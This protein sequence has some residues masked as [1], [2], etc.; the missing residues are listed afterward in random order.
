[1]PVGNTPPDRIKEAGSNRYP[2][3]ALYNSY[4]STDARVARVRRGHRRGDRGA[5]RG[6]GVRMVSLGVPL[7]LQGRGALPR[8][9]PQEEEEEGGQG[10][11]GGEAIC[12][13][14]LGWGWGVG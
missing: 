12:D 10:P 14:I 9:P 3:N 6:A 1:M 13:P 7:L 5:V 4:R 2:A 11:G 8:T